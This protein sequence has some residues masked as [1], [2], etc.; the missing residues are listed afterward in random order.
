MAVWV[1]SDGTAKSIFAKQHCLSDGLSGVLLESSE[2]P[3]DNPQVAADGKENF[4]AMWRQAWKTV[5]GE[6]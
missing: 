4:I 6:R 2:M 1:Q 3:A 5:N